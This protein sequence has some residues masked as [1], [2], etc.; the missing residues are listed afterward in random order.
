MAS[1]TA[2][3]L[4]DLG[5]VRLQ[6]ID[7]EPGVRYRV[8]RSTADAPTWVYVRGGEYLST[9]HTTII[10][11]YEY[12]P[13]VL[14]SYRLIEPVFYDDF[15]RAYPSAGTL[16]LTG[17][18]N[19]Y[20]STPD[21]AALDITGDIDIRADATITWG[22]TQQALV[23]KYV[24]TA[25]DQ[26]SYRFTVESNGR[27]RLTRSTDGISTTSITSTVAVPISSGRLAV[28]VTLDV[29]NGAAGHTATFY[30]ATHGLAGPWVQLGSPVI[31]AGVITNFSGPAAVEVGSSNS[32]GL[33]Q[34]VGQVHAAQI[35]NGIAGAIVANPDFAAQS[36]GT[37]NFVDSAGRTWTVQP[38]ASI[39]TIAPVPGS[40]WGTAN[41]GENWN[42]G[43]S[44]AGF[45]LYVNNG[46]GVIAS[47]SP[48]GQVAELV[49]DQI[50]GAEDAEVTWS[51]IYPGAA[52]LFD[53]QTEWSIGLRALDAGN[54]YMSTLIFL[55]D[56]SD[57]DVQLRID[58]LVGN[59]LTSLNV[60]VVVGEWVPGIAWH[61]RFR[62][63]GSTLSARA[64]Q[65]GRNEPS[66]WQVIVIDTSL[67]TGTGVYARG[68]KGSGTA[69][70]QWFGPIEVQSIPISIADTV[71]IT[72]LQDGVFLKSIV[73]PMLNRQLE[74]VDWDELTR[75][76]RT[77]FFD[78]KGRHEILGIAD[79]GS[80]ATFTLTFITYSK[81]ENRAVVAL[82]TYGGVMLLQPPGD[83]EDE[84]CPTAYS[85]TPEGYVMGDGTYSQGRTV[86]GKPLW[87]WSV[88]FTR[89]A[90][91]DTT[92]V[93][94]TTLTWTQLWEIIGPEGTWED[95]W[96]LWS[97]WQEIWLTAG[98]PL[99]FGGVI[100]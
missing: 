87:V 37:T 17:A 89:V 47:S 3:Y 74:C 50:P 70:E 72:P 66:D 62:V 67:A 71:T 6:L 91:A 29:N 19:S 57:Y 33:T 42:L 78:I 18:T 14:N 75:D 56:A 22:G 79:V 93:L 99:N 23:S 53:V 4:D 77:A 7:A 44:L 26:R 100:G 39:I 15:D 83:D 55:T 32:G 65:E 41:T 8:Q 97:T 40:S 94:P 76:T 16:S 12:T 59:V 85:G 92:S 48:T 13:N 5:R 82:L 69:Y 61:V 10:D 84:D 80:S 43:S 86:Y 98:N 58:K 54:A 60:P 35:R 24:V 1:L 49:T 46:V 96:A 45:S 63:Q 28:R 20:A 64:W 51:A 73:F 52:A 90:A 95:V 25:G 2:T 38:G 21:N 36:A 31:T 27:L 68:F 88:T 30:T 34:L 9:T 81:A 11:D